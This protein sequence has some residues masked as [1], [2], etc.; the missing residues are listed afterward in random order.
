[1]ADDAETAVD[2][3]PAM[4]DETDDS[5]SLETELAEE[6]ELATEEAS[7]RMLL[8]TSPA[9]EVRALAEEEAADPA[10]QGQ[11][12]SPQRDEGKEEK[13][14]CRSSPRP[15]R[16]ARPRWSIQP[17]ETL[18]SRG[19]PLL[20]QSCSLSHG[21]GVALVQEALAERGDE[22]RGVAE[23]SCGRASRRGSAPC[24]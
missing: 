17:R 23:S 20:S 8:A 19:A 6:R 1:M 21:G 10:A 14:S 24:V 3:T 9:V 4:A 5:I 18:T 15:I 13:V 11:V 12:E 7:L 22:T 2:D 16:R